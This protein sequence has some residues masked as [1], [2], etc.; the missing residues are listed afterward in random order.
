[1]PYLLLLLG[2]CLAFLAAAHLRKTP[3]DSF[4]ETLH[5]KLEGPLNSDL[6]TL[7]ALQELME[8]NLQELQEK[9]EMLQYLLVQ[10]EKQRESSALQLQ[11]LEKLLQQ[12][13]DAAE[14]AHVGPSNDWQQEQVYKLADQGLSVAEVAARLG[15][16]RGEVELIL[17]WRSA[18]I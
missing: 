18:K 15:L 5:A 16:G 4:D 7:V 9:N 11:Q 13:T 8:S 6:V 17:G 1:M 3:K 12:F 2:L 10:Q 14:P